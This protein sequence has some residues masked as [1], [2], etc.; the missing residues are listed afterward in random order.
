MKQTEQPVGIVECRSCKA[1]R[2]VRDESSCLFSISLYIRRTESYTS[3]SITK[4]FF[5]FLMRKL[6]HSARRTRPTPYFSKRGNANFD[7][8]F[9]CRM[10]NRSCRRV[11]NTK[12]NSTESA[13]KVSKFCQLLKAPK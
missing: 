13:E 6:F 4:V 5:F 7:P 12:K 10:E 8:H 9:F 2:I 1:Y 11:S 3:K